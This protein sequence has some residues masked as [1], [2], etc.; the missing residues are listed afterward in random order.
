MTLQ[1]PRSIDQALRGVLSLL[2]DGWAATRDPDDYEAALFR[3]LAAEIGTIEVSAFSMLAQIDP[4]TAP[5]LLPDWE[6]MLGPGPF[7]ASTP[8]TDT[9]T[10]GLIAYAQLTNAGTICAGYFERMALMIGETIT[11]T[12]FPAYACG[13]FECG[14]SML[15]Q[16]PEHC[17]FQV[18]LKATNVEEWVCGASQCGDSLGVF[19]P[20]VM[21]DVIRN[22][23][24]LYATP[25]FNYIT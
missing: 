20:S 9:V 4:R 23:A 22:G 1:P 17:A 16:P 5:N 6:R 12:E 3:P 14:A 15:V 2:P 18:T 24:P 21:E 7:A 13:A 19:T 10:R 11:I 25:Y 8:V